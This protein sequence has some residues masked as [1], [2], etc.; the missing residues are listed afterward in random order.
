[1]DLKQIRNESI[2]AAKKLGIGVSPTLPLL[3]AGLKMRNANEVVSRI[4]A[5]NAVAAAAYG[6]FLSCVCMTRILADAGKHVTV[7]K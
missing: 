1:M 5:M 4:L 6:S 3:D 7:T 2:R